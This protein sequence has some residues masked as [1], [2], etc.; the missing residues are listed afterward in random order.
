[1]KTLSYSNVKIVPQFHYSF[2]QSRKSNMKIQFR[3]SAFLFFYH[4]GMETRTTSNWEVIPKC[5]SRMTRAI[6]QEQSPKTL[7]VSTYCKMFL[8]NSVRLTF[9]PIGLCQN[10]WWTAWDRG[11][12]EGLQAEMLT[13]LNSITK[14]CSTL[15]QTRFM[16]IVQSEDNNISSFFLLFPHT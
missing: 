5:C 10:L 2:S 1:M 9:W 12:D 6:S 8:L 11:S 15:R 13:S 14:S 7:F 4:I 16:E 3:S